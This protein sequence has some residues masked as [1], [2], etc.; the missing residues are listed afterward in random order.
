MIVEARLDIRA[1]RWRKKAALKRR[2]AVMRKK[3]RATAD[4]LMGA[5]FRELRNR[6]RPDLASAQEFGDALRVTAQT[7]RNWEHGR[8]IPVP[9]QRAVCKLLGC[10]PADLWSPPGEMTLREAR[11]T[12]QDAAETLQEA[13]QVMEQISQKMEQMR[14]EMQEAEEQSWQ[15]IQEVRELY[16]MIVAKLMSMISVADVVPHGV[17]TVQ[18]WIRT[19]EINGYKESVGLGSLATGRAWRAYFMRDVAADFLR[20]VAKVVMPHWPGNDNG[21]NGDGGNGGQGAA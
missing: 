8:H 9:Q 14:Q 2:S 21:D 18:E 1:S 16:K 19:A 13:R 15:E 6:L 3:Q 5:R 17:E 12:I 7:V 11:E 10:A 4:S 20:D